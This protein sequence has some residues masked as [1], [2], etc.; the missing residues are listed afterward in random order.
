MDIK[1]HVNE[2]YL[3]S[4]RQNQLIHYLFEHIKSFENKLLL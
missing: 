4:K 2:L 1:L 3:C